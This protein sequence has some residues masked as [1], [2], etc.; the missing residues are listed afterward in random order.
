MK[1]VL[2]KTAPPQSPSADL[3]ARFVD[4]RLAWFDSS[5]QHRMLRLYARASRANLPTESKQT[6]LNGFATLS[7]L[8]T[9]RQST[10]ST[11]RSHR[12]SVLRVTL[13]I[14]ASTG[15]IGMS[16]TTMTDSFG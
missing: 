12:S 4:A 13:A 3:T 15:F 9:F 11:L 7:K 10:I 14:A 16:S 1:W 6:S 5:A 2:Q 8:A